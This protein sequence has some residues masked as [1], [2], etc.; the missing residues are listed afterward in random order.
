MV[1]M[2]HSTNGDATTIKKSI[3]N[4]M[5]ENHETDYTDISDEEADYHEDT[6]DDKKRKHTIILDRARSKIRSCYN[7]G[8]NA[9]LLKETIPLGSMKQ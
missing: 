2:N 4:A 6:T 9:K 8:I 1:F 5:A 3:P 7:C